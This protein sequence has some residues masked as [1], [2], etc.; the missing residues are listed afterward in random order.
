MQKEI[1]EV[2]PECGQE[3]QMNWDIENSGYKAYCPYCGA[4]LLLC[5]ECMHSDDYKGTCDY[6]ENGCFRAKLPRKKCSFGN[7]VIKPDGIHELD[8]HIYQEIERYGN[9]TV[10]VNKCKKC[11]HI[12]ISWSKQED[13]VQ[14][15][16]EEEDDG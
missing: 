2:C 4:H 10:H 14:M 15:D 7:V 1:V 16:L 8:P 5:D 11:G 13:T 6:N 3:I 9:V 12:D